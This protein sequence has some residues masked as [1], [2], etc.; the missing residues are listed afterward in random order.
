MDAKR[1]GPLGRKVLESLEEVEQM[2]RQVLLEHPQIAS[3]ASNASMPNLPTPL[4]SF[5]Q[6]NLI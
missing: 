6:P 2:P 4:T 5:R 3:N 1:L